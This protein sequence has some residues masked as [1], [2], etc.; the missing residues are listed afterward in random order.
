MFL[1]RPS[2]LRLDRRR[3]LKHGLAGA[4]MITVGT[5]MAS[6]FNAATGSLLGRIDTHSRR[7]AFLDALRGGLNPPDGNGVRLPAGFASRIVARSGQPVA[8]ARGTAPYVWHGAPDGGATYPTADGGWIYVSNAELGPGQGGVG[9]LVFDA[10]GNVVDGYRILDGTNRNCAG[11]PTPWNTWLSC[12]EHD[13]GLTWECDPYGVAPAVAHPALGSF[14][15]EAAAVDPVRKLV[16]QTEDEG[17]SGFYKFVPANYPDL[18]TGVLQVAQVLGDPLGGERCR[19]IWHTVPN[20]NP[21]KDETPTRHQVPGTYPFVRGEGMWYHDGIVYFATTGDDRVW[22]Y[23]VTDESIQVLYDAKTVA[24]NPLREPDNVVVDGG[25]FVYVAEDSDD[26]QIVLLTPDGEA[27]PFVQLVGHDRSEICG[28]AF[29][30]D[31]TRLYFSSQRGTSGSSDDG[32]VFEVSGPFL[33]NDTLLRDGF[34]RR[35]DD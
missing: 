18:S 12:E 32:I 33:G 30:P 35:V 17:D 22:A 10:H 16:F 29:S 8:N 23:R 24:S 7:A 2:A 20:P 4:G 26:L 6:G 15:H 3:F 13:Q 27:M 19:V 9:A 31:G 34:E 1:S 21:K 25:G 5:S 14:T 11:G 28:P